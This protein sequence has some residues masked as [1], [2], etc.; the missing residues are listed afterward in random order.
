[1]PVIREL[2]SVSCLIGQIPQAVVLIAAGAV[3]KAL[4]RRND[5]VQ[6]IVLAGRKMLNYVTSFKKGSCL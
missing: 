1:I 6:S 5:S 3:A 2:V 4:M